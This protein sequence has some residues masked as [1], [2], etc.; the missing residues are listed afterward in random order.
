MQDLLCMLATAAF[1]AVAAGLT[2][3]FERLEREDQ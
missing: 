2:R 3:T 1:F